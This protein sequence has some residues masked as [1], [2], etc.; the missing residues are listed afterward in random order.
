MNPKAALNP[1][2][3]PLLSIA[4]L[5]TAMV[6]IQYGATFAKKLFPLI[7]P[8]GS[9]GVRLTLA[10]VILFMVW[11]P[12]R[13]PRLKRSE[14]KAIGLYGVSLG[15]MN[16]L[17]YEALV[18][19]PLG[20]AV[21]LEFTGPL[22]VALLLSRKKKDFLWVT[23]AAIGLLLLLPTGGTMGL[24]LIGCAFAL[25]AGG[26]WAMYILFG[27][28]A[29]SSSLSGGRITALGM[30]AATLVILPVALFQEG[31]KL[32][33]PSFLPL[34]LAVALLSSAIPY[35]LEMSVLKKMPAKTFGI[36]M[37]LEPAIAATLGLIFLSEKLYLSQI[38]AIAS[39]MAASLGSALSNR[40][41]KQENQKRSNCEGANLDPS[42]G[43]SEMSVVELGS[44]PNPIENRVCH[45]D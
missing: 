23:L 41:S 36:L 30:F 29:G 43:S 25:G 34:A 22:S 9:T 19:I 3:S 6:S 18:R 17:F 13:G 8:V 24:D 35:T 39:I 20:P 26:C 42:A 4:T 40:N 10:T 11:K 7:G 31:L 14:I 16:L 5:L 44:E 15:W 28:K 2:A 21:A 32:F 38:F 12:W 37:S 1:K 45:S 27:Q 33:Q